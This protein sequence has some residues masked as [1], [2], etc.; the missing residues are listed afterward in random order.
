MR[1]YGIKI[2]TYTFLRN[3]SRFFR[4]RSTLFVFTKVCHWALTWAS[5]FH[6]SLSQYFAME[7]MIRLV[8]ESEWLAGDHILRRLSPH[9]VSDDSLALGLNSCVTYE[10][11]SASMRLQLCLVSLI[12]WWIIG[13]MHYAAHC[14]V[15]IVFRWRVVIVAPKYYYYYYYYCSSSFD[16]CNW[17]DVTDSV[18]A[19]DIILVWYSEEGSGTSKRNVTWAYI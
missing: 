7:I 5:W 17:P 9:C 18:T 19:L 10:L 11:M 13:L 16:V 2:G 6:P 8:I 14:P 3:C 15:C 12:Y 1:P 4:T